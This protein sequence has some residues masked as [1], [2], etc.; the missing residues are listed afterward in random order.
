MPPIEPIRIE[1]PDD[2]VV[3]VLRRL[4]PGERLAIANRMWVSARQV[5]GFIVRR[6]H[7]DWSDDQ[8][9]HE[10]VRRMLHGAV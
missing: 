9:Q 2:A 10:I 8:V 5:V 6:D 1:V 7:P 4:T 3:E